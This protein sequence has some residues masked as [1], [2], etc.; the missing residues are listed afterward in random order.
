[1]YKIIT[2][3]NFATSVS[4]FDINKLSD[5]EIQNY[6]NLSTLYRSLLNEYIKQLGLGNY[7]DAVKNS[8]LNFIPIKSSDQDFYQYYN[9]S[10]LDYYYVRNNIYIDCLTEKEKE[11]LQNKLNKH[12][13]SLSDQDIDF[14]SQTLSKV[15]KEV[16]DNTPE[17]FEVNFGPLSTSFF[18][19]NNALVLGFRYDKFNDNGMDE[20]IFVDNYEKQRGFCLKLNEQLEIELQNRLPVPVKVIEYDENSIKKNQ[21]YDS[22]EKKGRFK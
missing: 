22:L 1:M 18:A 2:K 16:H 21:N 4:E 7:E 19:P 13:Y 10:N 12:D 20:D 5:T 3:E 11:Y 8:E 14:V 17:P 15:I 6:L 9:N